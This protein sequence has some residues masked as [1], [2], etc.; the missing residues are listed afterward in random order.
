MP[1]VGI[2][3]LFCARGRGHALAGWQK[4]LIHC[5]KILQCLPYSMPAK[6]LSAMFSVCRSV[7]AYLTL[8]KGDSMRPWGGYPNAPNVLGTYVL[9]RGEFHFCLVHCV[10]LLDKTKNSSPGFPDL[11][12]P[13]E[14]PRQ[15]QKMRLALPSHSRCHGTFLT[16]F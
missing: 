2:H 1:Q 16:S 13:E 10:R 6:L 8:P 15:S 9:H 12:W 7:L 5:L 3:K 11:G 4:N 14:Q